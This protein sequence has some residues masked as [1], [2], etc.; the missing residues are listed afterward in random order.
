MQ[1][2]DFTEAAGVNGSACRYCMK[3]D[4]SGIF[5]HMYL[6][7]YNKTNF[8]D[9]KLPGRFE[10][11]RMMLIFAFLCKSLRKSAAAAFCSSLNAAKGHPH[12]RFI[13]E[14]T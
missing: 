14:E 12:G 1:N 4:N 10:A 9:E 7:S 8:A 11:L 13:G 6:L 2:D 5:A 3:K